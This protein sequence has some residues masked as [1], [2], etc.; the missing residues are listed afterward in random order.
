MPALREYLESIQVQAAT[1]ADKLT[2]EDLEY[3]GPE[4]DADYSRLANIW[5]AFKAADEAVGNAL[6]AGDD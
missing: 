6:D 3:S 1:L 5:S 2:A 4:S